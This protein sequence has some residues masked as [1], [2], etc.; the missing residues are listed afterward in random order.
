MKKFIALALML[1][2]VLAFSGCGKNNVTVNN[3][4]S[5]LI[6][7]YIAGTLLKYSYENQWKYT[8][9]N[10]AKNQYIPNNSQQM[11]T[12]QQTTQAQNTV[13]T[14]GAGQQPSA[15]NSSADPCDLL[16][17]ALGLA[18]ATIRYKAY[19]VGDRYPTGEYV[20][21]VPAES[22][23]KVVAVEFTI[24]NTSGNTITANTASSGVSMKLAVNGS[25]ESGY[26]SMLKNDMLN[27]KSVAIEPGQDYTAVV[28]FQVKAESADGIDGSVLS[29]TSG[30]SKLGTLTLH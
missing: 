30:G 21:C 17:D 24:T 5:N 2:C 26:T 8:K 22:G 11:P 15:G 7:E 6:S 25:N 13:V 18:G 29:V 19:V 20:V 10:T 12:A 28:L 1:I 3:E 27:L 16:P 23:C 14:P 9:L 4:Q